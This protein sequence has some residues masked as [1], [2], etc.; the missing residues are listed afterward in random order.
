MQDL[1]TLDL[2]PYQYSGV[3]FTG[4]RLVDVESPDAQKTFNDFLYE[5]EN[6]DSLGQLRVEPAL[7]YDAVQLFARAFKRFQDAVKGNVRSLSCDGADNWE[8]GESLRNY[9]RTVSNP[10]NA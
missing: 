4:V 1:H 5:M 8:L 7:M 9:L 10:V 6:V 3:N 2:E